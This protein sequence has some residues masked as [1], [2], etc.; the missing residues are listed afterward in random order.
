LSFAAIE[1]SS[2]CLLRSIDSLL[3]N[4]DDPAAS[5]L[6]G[7]VKAAAIAKAAVATEKWGEFPMCYWAD[8]A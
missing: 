8:A 7:A 2:A 6:C 5:A 4:F 3:L 1:L